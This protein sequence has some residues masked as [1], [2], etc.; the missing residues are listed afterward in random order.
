MISTTKFVIYQMHILLLNLC[1]ISFFINILV[2]AD[3]PYWYC[4]DANNNRTSNILFQTNV[5][6]LLQ[7]LSSNAS[8]SK[9]Y[10]I[11]IK[12]GNYTTY[13]HYLCYDYVTLE[14][15]KTSINMATQSI[16]RL[17]P[18]STDAMV[19][20][21]VSQL[22]ISNQRFFGKLDT[23]GN[24]NKYNVK[25]VAEPEKFRSVVNSS[26]QDLALKATAYNSSAHAMYA[27]QSVAFSDA[28][29]VHSLV[30][31]TLDVSPVDCHRCLQTAI[32]EVLGSD[33]YQY[34]GGRLMSKSCYLR[35]ELYAFYEGKTSEEPEDQ[36][37]QG[38][39][40]ILGIVLACI[41][42]ALVGSFVFYF[43]L[44]GRKLGKNFH[45]RDSPLYDL[46]SI[47]AATDNF[48][49]KNKLG[50]GGFGPVYMG[51]LQDGSKVAVKRLAITSDQG[52][53]EF[54]NEVLLIM[55]LQHKNLVR[56][57]GF[58]VEG[59]ERLLIY[60]LMPSGGLDSWLY[61]PQ[62]REQLT[63]SKQT[64][65][66]N[67][68]AHGVLYLHED[69]RQTIIHRDL[70][71]GNVL[72]DHDLNPKISDFGNARIYENESDNEANTITVIGT[73]GYMAPE[74]AMDGVYSVKSD[75]FSFGV[76]LLE[77]IT[78]RQSI[79]FH[80]TGNGP[81]LQAYVWRLWSQGRWK[82]LKETNLS[83]DNENDDEFIR[84]L[85]IGLLC[86]QEDPSERPTMS[87]VVHMLKTENVKLRPPKQPA[88]S[89]VRLS[90]HYQT[91]PR[92][93]TSIRCF[94][95]PDGVL[96]D[97]TKVA[98]KRLARRTWQGA[99]EL[100][101]E[102][103]LIA[104][105]QH[106]NLVRLIG[107][108]IESHE[109][110]LVYELLPKKSLDLYIYDAGKRAELIWEIRFAIIS[111]IARGLL[112]LHEGSRLKIIHRD[113][114]PSNILL[115]QDMN[116]KISDFGIARIICDDQTTAITKRVVGT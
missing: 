104:N 91:S 115:D 1:L 32:E 95:L 113:L 93:S 90:D 9:Y 16:T 59:A 68:I 15:C 11:S 76:I 6:S 7:S 108:G 37:S 101:T 105:L 75:V 74:Y 60:E 50:E 54:R 3:P 18:N 24:I 111:G 65:I 23:I 86:V 48:S 22:H 63:W 8:Y 29:R 88:F 44:R 81:S 33:N 42:A 77:I 57:L 69:S 102:I 61:D 80:L 20:E 2:L 83:N 40:R 35:Y 28:E 107:S 116:A 14:N 49:E 62:K 39:T 56:L 58:C 67:G 114:K 96:P 110:I 46:A 47:H 82:E 55:K 72:L 5:D 34:R 41:T 98:V 109:K 89:L 73:Y 99:A 53:E 31:C 38:T 30:Q 71:P 45:G 97:G 84:C 12:N 103:M 36:G 66:I 70:K 21:E 112:Y 85:H 13:G 100:K 92:M 64:V 10:N 19:W 52:T 106:R 4:P 43:V 51:V 27:T 26:L 78:G 79:G 94:T 87:L 25:V 17:C